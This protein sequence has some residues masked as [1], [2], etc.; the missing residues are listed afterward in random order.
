ML[1]NSSFSNQ[2][3]FFQKIRSIDYILLISI[4]S[5]GLISCFAMYST[6]GG[7][8]LYHTKNHAIRFLIFFTVMLFV[9]FINIKIWHTLSYIFYLVTLLLLVLASFY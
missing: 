6:D 1:N 5:V 3:T 2:L 7:E 4:F 9:S 8:M